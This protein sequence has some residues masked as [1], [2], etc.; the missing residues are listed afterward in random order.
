MTEIF[1]GENTDHTSIPAS[2]RGKVG[3][4]SEQHC[5]LECVLPM[6]GGWNWVIV[7]VPSNPGH[8]DSMNL[9]C[10]VT[11]QKAAA[12]ISLFLD[13]YMHNF[14]KTSAEKS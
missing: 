1:S 12:N 13:R 5:L 9:Y 4:G 14:Y 2:L 7:K 11:F 10:P 8:S 3:W 6:A